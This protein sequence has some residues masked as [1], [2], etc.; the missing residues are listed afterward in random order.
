MLTGNEE[1]LR[2]S[3]REQAKKGA[4]SRENIPPLLA[5]VREIDVLPE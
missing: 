5:K 3:P 1:Q 4:E 2:K